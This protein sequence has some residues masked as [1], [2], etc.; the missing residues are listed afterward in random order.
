[1]SPQPTPTQIKGLAGVE[2]VQIV[3]GEHHTIACTNDGR[4]FTWGRNDEG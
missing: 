2:V 1:V 3:G 4:V